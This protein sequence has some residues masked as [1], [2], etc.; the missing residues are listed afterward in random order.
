MQGNKVPYQIS[1]SELL[2]TF[3]LFIITYLGFSLGIK[4]DDKEKNKLALST[5]KLTVIK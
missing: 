2:K 4:E 5:S 3:I 1:T